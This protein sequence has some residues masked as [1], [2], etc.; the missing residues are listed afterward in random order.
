MYE[1]LLEREVAPEQA[2]MVLPQSMMTE[3]IWTGSLMAFA[4]IVKLTFEE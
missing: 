3:W 4:R 1:K 2:R